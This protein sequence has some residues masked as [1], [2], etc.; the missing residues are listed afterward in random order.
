MLAY[1]QHAGD[2]LLN[3]HVRR[4]AAVYEVTV[5]NDLCNAIA[6][7]PPG[8]ERVGWAIEYYYVQ[9]HWYVNPLGTSFQILY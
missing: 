8:M 9:K 1:L 7:V 6:R 2:P 4:D 3:V 5:Q